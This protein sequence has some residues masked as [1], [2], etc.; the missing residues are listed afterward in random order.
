MRRINMVCTNG[1]KA[2]A[3][4]YMERTRLFGLYWPSKG[5]ARSDDGDSSDLSFSAPGLTYYPPECPAIE[6]QPEPTKDEAAPDLLS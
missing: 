4:T 1:A 5:V 2:V 3:E 6:A